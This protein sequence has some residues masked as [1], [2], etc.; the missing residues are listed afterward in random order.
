MT[1]KSRETLSRAT[2]ILEGLSASG[3]LTD[4]ETNLIIAVSEMIDTVLKQD[5]LILNKEDTE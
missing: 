4:A 1:H 2:G 5:L 3:N